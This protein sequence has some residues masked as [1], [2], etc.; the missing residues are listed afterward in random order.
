MGKISEVGIDGS[1]EV[2]WSDEIMQ[3]FK[4]SIVNKNVVQVSVIWM[5]DDIRSG[6]IEKPKYISKIVDITE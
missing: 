3:I 2:D 5:N 6:L 1:F 4:S